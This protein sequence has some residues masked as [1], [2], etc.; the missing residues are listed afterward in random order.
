[1]L[2]HLNHLE[3]IPTTPVCENLSPMKL[4]PGS[5]KVGDHCFSGCGDPS[6][7]DIVSPQK[8]SACKGPAQGEKCVVGPRSFTLSGKV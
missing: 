2:M 5:K 6:M 4:V 8:H 3:T 7:S 1:M